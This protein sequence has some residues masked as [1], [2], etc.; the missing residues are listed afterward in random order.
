MWAHVLSI[1]LGVWLTAAPSV[2]GYGG[3]ARIN[4][5]VVGPLA[6]SAAAVALSEVTRPVRWVNLL[7]GGWLVV[8]PVVIEHSSGVAA[9]GVLVG[10]LLAAGAL[11]RGRVR[12]RY[13]GGWS[14]VWSGRPAEA[15][16]S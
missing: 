3:G 4:A 13:G 11:V 15:E 7:L 12:A 8:A 16:E 14:A 2:L 6:A 1:L 9:H 5:L 10:G